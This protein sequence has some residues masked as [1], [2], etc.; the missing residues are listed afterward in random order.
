MGNGQRCADQILC[1]YQASNRSIKHML[2]N[3]LARLKRF[4]GIHMFLQSPQAVP[5][6]RM[7]LVSLL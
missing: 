4:F 3:E 5:Q 1:S 2:K 6:H 7:M